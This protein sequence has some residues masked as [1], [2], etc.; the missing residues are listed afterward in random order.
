MDLFDANLKTRA[1]LSERVRPENLDVNKL[2]EESGLAY[3]NEKARRC[4]KLKSNG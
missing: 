3:T 2:M 4:R 1:P